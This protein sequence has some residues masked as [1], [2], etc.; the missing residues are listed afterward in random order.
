MSN[1]SPKQ[2]QLGHQ[3]LAAV[4]FLARSGVCAEQEF[5]YLL[6]RHE[7]RL[8]GLCRCFDWDRPRYNFLAHCPVQLVTSIERLLGNLNRHQDRS[9]QPGY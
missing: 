8:P 7:A 1:S 6:R 2:G 4:F 3:I 5:R 9:G